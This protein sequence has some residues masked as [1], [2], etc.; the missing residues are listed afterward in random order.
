M[1]ELRNRKDAQEG[2]VLQYKVCLGVLQT[3]SGAL[4]SLVGAERHVPCRCFSLVILITPSDRLPHV[5]VM[6]PY[7]SF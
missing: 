3:G 2:S 4:K 5:N 1:K 6:H 7:N